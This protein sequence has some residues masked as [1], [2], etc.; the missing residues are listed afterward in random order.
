MLALIKTIHTIIF[1]F[2]AG[3]V[4]FILYCGIAKIFGPALYVALGLISIEG[5]VFFGNGMKCPLTGMAKKYGA[6][7]GYVFDSFFPEKWTRY[8]FPVFGTILGI[9][10]FLLLLRWNGF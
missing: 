6:T 8:T 5:I 1:I 9:G 3:S 10:L 2:M 7:K 4:F